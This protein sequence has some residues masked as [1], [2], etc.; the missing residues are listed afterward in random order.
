LVVFPYFLFLIKQFLVFSQYLGVSN[1]Q[2]TQ[3]ALK[4]ISQMRLNSRFGIQPIPG[5]V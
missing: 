4:M 2:K 3:E 1:L 5:G